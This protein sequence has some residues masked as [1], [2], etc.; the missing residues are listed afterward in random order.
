MLR[1]ITLLQIILLLIYTTIFTLYIEVKYISVVTTQIKTIPLK[2]GNKL[3][4]TLWGGT[5]S[6]K[7]L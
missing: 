3:L 2:R 6:R 1:N 4:P 5:L 7:K